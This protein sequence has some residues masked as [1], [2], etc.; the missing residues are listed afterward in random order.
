[1][2]MWNMYKYFPPKGTVEEYELWEDKGRRRAWLLD[3]P[4]NV[5]VSEEKVG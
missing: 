5:E 2:R 3:G 1:M 4:H